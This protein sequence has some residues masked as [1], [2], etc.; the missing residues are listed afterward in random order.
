M[1]AR[2]ASSNI[3]LG[4]INKARCSSPLHLHNIFSSILSHR[5]NIV[6]DVYKRQ[7]GKLGAEPELIKL[8]A[9]SCQK[10]D[11]FVLKEGI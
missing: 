1:L 6:E 2:M 7:C 11:I 3:Y 9:D 8:L 5:M 4:A 10:R